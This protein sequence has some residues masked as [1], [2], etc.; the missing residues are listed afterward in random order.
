MFLKRR[1]VIKESLRPFVIKDGIYGRD[2]VAVKPNDGQLR[3]HV[4]IHTIQT[5]VF[6]LIFEINL[7]IY[8]WNLYLSL[9][10]FFDVDPQVP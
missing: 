3:K 6:K 1:F 5:Y 7:C 8:L 2:I 9:A 10:N 4:I